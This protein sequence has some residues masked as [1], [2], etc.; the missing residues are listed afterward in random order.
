M[1]RK[2]FYNNLNFEKEDRTLS[3]QI[4]QSHVTSLLQ[5]KLNLPYI[6]QMTTKLWNKNFFL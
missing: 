2:M 6:L 1:E 4:M 5:D 3:F